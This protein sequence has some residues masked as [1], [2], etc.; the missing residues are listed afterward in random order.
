MTKSLLRGSLILLIGLNF[1]NLVNYLFNV[2]M[3][4]MLGPE[5]YGLLISLFALIY[6]VAVP[7][8]T[9]ITV[10]MKFTSDYKARGE[11]GKINSLLRY[12]SKRVALLS[13]ICFILIAVASPFIAQFIHSPSVAPIILVGVSLI[14]FF[15][16][17]VNR[18][19][20][21]GLQNFTDFVVNSN[22]DPIVK[23]ILGV[24]LVWIGWGVNGTLTAMIVAGIAAYVF[25]FL[26]LRNFLS[27]NNQIIETKK[28]KEYSFSSLIA[29]F[30]IAVF[31][32]IDI[33][34]VKHYFSPE[35]AGHY[36]ALAT[37]GKII[38]FASTPIVSAMFPMIAER[39]EQKKH[40]FD[41]LFNTLAMVSAVSSI[42]V[43][44][45]YLAPQLVIK[46]LFGPQYIT[47][48]PY[49]GAFGVA[50]LLYSLVN[51]M[52]NYYLSIHRLKFIPWLLVMAV[53][54][55]MLIT[56]YH[57]NFAQIINILI[58]TMGA[59]LFGLMFMHLLEKKDRIL[60]LRQ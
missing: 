6:I 11:I 58:L 19:I 38:L 51:V 53:L 26:S 9:I 8:T 57:Q 15:L 21:Q 43:I 46:Y 36:G 3:G 54:E 29:L 14:M 16:I 41:L 42:V 5:D 18:G 45:Y 50:V 2:L 40:H 47:V 4:R 48:Y 32:N 22:I 52:V 30:L 24:F 49:L 12:L 17:P 39:H 59:T 13:L 60:N 55:I 31:I 23:I 33:I 37:L 25:S 34:L 44:I 27:P 20:L 56:F 28:I 10:A 1:V 7:S 35:E